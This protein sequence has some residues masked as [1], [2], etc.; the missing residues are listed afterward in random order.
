MQG[1]PESRGPLL[2]NE[3]RAP[4]LPCTISVPNLIADRPHW[5]AHQAVPL[6]VRRLMYQTLIFAFVLGN[7]AGGLRSALDAQDLEGLAHAL[8]DP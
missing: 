7:E 4:G 6:N 8:V 2:G 3:T 1:R 5:L